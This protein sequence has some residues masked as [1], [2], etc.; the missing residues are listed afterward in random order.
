MNLNK[1]LDKIYELENINDGLDKEKI[2]HLLE[3]KK[4]KEELEKQLT[5]KR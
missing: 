5:E 3:Q 4:Q 1:A 2:L